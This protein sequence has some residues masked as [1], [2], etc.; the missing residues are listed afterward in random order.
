[1]TMTVFNR[2][3]SALIALVL[4]FGGLLLAIEVT[5]AQLG[6]PP[7]LIPHPQWN[8]WLG[9]QT[10]HSGTVRAV[11]VGVAAVGLLLIVTAV[12]RGRPA[13]FTLGSS[14]GVRVSASRKGVQRS[15][16]DAARRVDGI[17]SARV[18]A[19]RR[20]VIVQAA[21]PARTAGLDRQVDAAVTDQIAA[22]GLPPLRTR[23]SITHEGER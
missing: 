2:L 6:R 12:R 10:W 23:V 4:V 3:L 13:D 19:G 22:L 16:S 7:W 8:A 21:T 15:L 5:L 20:R 14:D 17:T 1:M 11:L 9:Q 18:T